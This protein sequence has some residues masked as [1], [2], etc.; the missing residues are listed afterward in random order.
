MTMLLVCFGAGLAGA[1]PLCWAGWW[2]SARHRAVQPRRPSP[3]R[4][5]PVVLDAQLV[6][7]AD[8]E[9]AP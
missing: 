9:L 8:D 2:I 5:Q 1:L 7:G 6:A 4:L 3:F